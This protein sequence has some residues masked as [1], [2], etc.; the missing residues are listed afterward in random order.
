MFRN[1]RA[2]RFF[3]CLYLWCKHR[4]AFLPP[5]PLRFP[6]K[7]FVWGKPSALSP[8]GQS[9]SCTAKKE[10]VVS[11]L[12]GDQLKKSARNREFL[13][14]S[15]P[16]IGT[17]APSAAAS[18]TKESFE[19][20]NPKLKGVVVGGGSND[21]VGKAAAPQSG[22]GGRIEASSPPVDATVAGW[23]GAGW[24]EGQSWVGNGNS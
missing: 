8:K 12:Q 1:H 19:W 11:F 18:A 3:N 10:S 9:S 6:L 20:P 16:N 23:A 15:L 2:M 5:V 13:F 17:A 14:F 4:A 22:P 24:G 21:H 7:V